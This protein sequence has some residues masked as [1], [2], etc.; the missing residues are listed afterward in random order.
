MTSLQVPFRHDPL[1]HTI[2]SL[3]LVH[4]LPELSE[5]GQIQCTIRHTTTT[6]RYVCLS[7]TW[8]DPEPLG[9]NSV[10]INRKPFYIREN[11]LD[12]LRMMQKT[13]SRDD[14]I[15]DET[16]GYWI[17]ALCIDQK[18]TEERNHQVAQMGSVFSRA[19]FVHIWLGACKAIERTQSLIYGPERNMGP[20]IGMWYIHYGLQLMTRY[21]FRNKYW[22]RAWVIQ[23][24][25]LAQR[26]EVSLS[27]QRIPFPMFMDGLQPLS[28]AW[29]GITHFK[30]Y[31][32]H[33]ENMKQLCNNSLMEFLYHFENKDCG[34]VQDRIFSLLAL[35]NDGGDIP[36]RY[37]MSRNELAYQV[38]K[39]RAR[40]ACL[41]TAAIVAQALALRTPEPPTTGPTG[42]TFLHFDFI[43]VSIESFGGSRMRRR[44]NGPKTRFLYKRDV[45]G[46]TT[47][48]W[49]MPLSRGASALHWC[50]NLHQWLLNFYNEVTDYASSVSLKEFRLSECSL[51]GRSKL[52]R[53][54]DAIDQMKADM[55]KYAGWLEL[56]QPLK[57]HQTDRNKNIVSFRTPLSSLV[58]N[59][60]NK[61]ET[62][63]LFAGVDKW[64]NRDPVIT[65]NEPKECSLIAESDKWVNG[66]PAI[67]NIRFSL[68][69]CQNT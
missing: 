40:T 36:V 27:V 66:D 54:C 56:L 53:L 17:D 38:L 57:I 23:E 52:V 35:C 48:S 44:G 34:F 69:T 13:A 26:V 30:Q 55:H 31:A 8:G 16:R 3:R 1:D 33:F 28:Y 68:E 11:L 32:A 58:Q 59:I 50:T 24:V 42:I 15:F 45:Q 29:R 61:A 10:L 9:R 22:T 47:A 12:F 49:E 65:P 4:L 25:V 67:T 51:S 39:S 6:A 19:E 62:L 14:A 37:D 64:Q 43:D 18:N 41:C 5:T 60:P 46:Q 20:K 63:S 2:Q 21:I 7:Y